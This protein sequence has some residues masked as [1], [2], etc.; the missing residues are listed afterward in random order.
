MW[1][2]NTGGLF[3]VL[4]WVLGGKASYP[5]RGREKGGP[6][7]IGMSTKKGR[8]GRRHTILRELE[9][10][11]PL[12]ETMGPL[13]SLQPMG[14]ER[15]EAPAGLDRREA[16]AASDQLGPRFKVALRSKREALTAAVPTLIVV[17]AG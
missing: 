11:R 2:C 5:L 12:A 17:L 15:L 6:R 14:K 8:S 9:I 1:P 10:H 7:K 4:A 16:L 3:Y 13:A